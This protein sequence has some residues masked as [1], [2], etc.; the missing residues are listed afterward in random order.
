MSSSFFAQIATL[1]LELDEKT[2]LRKYFT[3]HDETKANQILFSITIKNEKVAYLR[4]FL[5]HGWTDEDRTPSLWLTPT[6]STP[7]PTLSITGYIDQGFI[8]KDYAFLLNRWYHIAYTLSEPEK[9]MNF[10]IDGK[11]IGS[12]SITNVQSQSII[13][14][15]GPLYIGKHLTRSGFTGQIK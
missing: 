8:V 13:F 14:N 15:D 6:D 12:Y 9:R 4:T 3:D 7:N 2:R 11:W 1:P 5:E 10:Y